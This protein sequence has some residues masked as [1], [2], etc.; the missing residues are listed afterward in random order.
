[1]Q[2]ESHLESV[3]QSANSTLKLLLSLSES[4]KAVE[5]QTTDFQAQ[6]EDILSDQK[7]TSK[8][9][10]DLA[11]NLQYY[12]YLEPITRRLNAPG[13]G[14]FVRRTEFSEMLSNL[15]TC[16]DYMQAHVRFPDQIL[17]SVTNK[18][19]SPNNASRPVMPRNID[20]SLRGH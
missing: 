7:K 1:V 19:C 6:C 20:F 11:G 12:N 18:A 3:L 13:A 8:L 4:F 16:I 2:T 5:A 9:A 17:S 10:E 14:N 15:D